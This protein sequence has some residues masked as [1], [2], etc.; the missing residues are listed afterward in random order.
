MPPVGRLAV[1]ESFHFIVNKYIT[2][3]ERFMSNKYLESLMK[4]SLQIIEFLQTSAGNSHFYDLCKL[5]IHVLCILCS[6][7][8]TKFHIPGETNISEIL[9]KKAF[10]CGIL[11]IL[12]FINSHLSFKTKD[13]ALKDLK[14][15]I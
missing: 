5:S 2:Q 4:Q 6:A 9:R 10:D 11:S 8:T 15:Y 1:V 7:K 12:T 13:Q 3:R 14:E